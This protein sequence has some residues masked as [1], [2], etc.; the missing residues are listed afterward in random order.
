MANTFVNT[1][2]ALTGT[3]ASI[4]TCP[5]GATAIV[6]MA[7][8][9]NVDNT[10]AAPVTLMW[11]DGAV[12]T[13]LA[14]EVSVPAYAAIG[15]LSGKLVLQ[16]GNILKANSDASSRIEITFSVLEIT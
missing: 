16:P 10:G 3:S 7:Q 11:N 12:D 9:A 1:A 5:V 13:H 6:L 15:L 8:A 4:Y 2:A 14:K